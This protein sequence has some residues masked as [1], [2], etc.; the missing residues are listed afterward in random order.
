VIAILRNP[1]TTHS[2]NTLSFVSTLYIR[3][4][5][6]LLVADVPPIWQ[7]D[8]RLG[9]QEA[10]VNAAKHGNCL[11]PS[12]RVLV[13]FGHHAPMYQWIIED[14]GGGFACCCSQKPQPGVEIAD[15]DECGR[16]VYILQQIF[17]CVEWNDCGNRLSLSKAIHRHSGIPLLL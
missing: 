10:L 5:L 17:D 15:T 6:D 11:D 7:A 9:L 12:K 13:R 8:I 16:G 3:P 1:T 2:W 4:V 14:E